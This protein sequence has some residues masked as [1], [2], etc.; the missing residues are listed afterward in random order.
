MPKIWKTLEKTSLLKSPFFE[1]FK[2]R[3]ETFH[4]KIMESYYRMELGDWVQVV[5]RTVEGE[6]VMIEQYRHGNKKM[7]LEIVGGAVDPGEEHLLA[8]KRELL[9]ETGY[10]G[11]DWVLLTESFPNPALQNN[12]MYTYF[13]DNVK[14]VSE[15]ALDPYEEI[16]VVL[17]SE[18]Q[19]KEQVNQGNIDHS[20]ILMSLLLH[21]KEF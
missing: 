20:L 6:Y 10:E 17:M 16:E 7:H 2:E 3:V 19:L 13:A 8:A 12:K 5:A 1:L 11:K 14:K 4:N 15:Q 18:E 9:E 21:F